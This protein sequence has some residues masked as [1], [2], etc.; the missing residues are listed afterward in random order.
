M[1]SH[2]EVLGVEANA[3]ESEIKKAYRSLSFKHHPDRC[4]DENSGEIMQKL[5]E[6]YEV[7]RDPQKRQQY[8]AELKGIPQMQG[9]HGG[10][11]G[12]PGFPGGMHGMGGGGNLFDMLFQQMA[13]GINIEIMHNGNGATFIRRHIGKPETITKQV[14]ISLEQAFTG[15]IAQIEIERWTMRKEDGLRIT[16]TETINVQIPAGIDNGENIL[17]EGVGNCIEEGNNRGDVKICVSVNKHATF[18]RNGADLHL[19]KTLTL[20][21]SLCGTQFHFEHLNGKN[22]TLN[23]TNAIIFPGGR[24]VFPNMG[25]QKKDGSV[26]N[27][28]IEFDVQFPET[29]TPE[30]KQ[31]LS[32]IL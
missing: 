20:K 31:Q 6:A 12:F 7:L 18:V 16:E 15:I 26:G 24:K 29:L 1:P 21:E 2:Y 32:N 17:L 9:F 25:M 10:F 3:D 4:Q 28:V 19:K 23:V 11:P 5:N 14:N 8:D 27:L 30:Q 13:G 22:L